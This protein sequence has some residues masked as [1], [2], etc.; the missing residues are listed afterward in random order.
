[1]K[2]QAT[3]S[4]PVF[5]IILGHSPSGLLYSPAHYPPMWPQAQAPA[6][7][8]DENA[9]EWAVRNTC[10]GFKEGGGAAGILALIWISAFLLIHTSDSG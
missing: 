3:F 5:L 8:H 2:E 7:E 4:V 6:S 1:M 10:Q 9:C